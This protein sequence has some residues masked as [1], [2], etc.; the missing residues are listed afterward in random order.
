MGWLRQS[1]PTLITPSK[2]GGLL[3]G[4]RAPGLRSAPHHLT[5]SREDRVSNAYTS[6]HARL[7]EVL[8]DEDPDGVGAS[9]LSPD[10]EYSPYVT[11]LIVQ[12]KDLRDRDE[13]ASAVRAMFGTETT[14]SLVEAVFDAWSRFRREV[15]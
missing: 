14:E 9:A 8:Y 13:V 12:L 7:C 2:S 5:Q 1:R 3:V 6:L 11:R 10:D 4:S 15:E